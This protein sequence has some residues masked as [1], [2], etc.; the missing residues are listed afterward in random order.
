[1]QDTT[2][3]Q[4]QESATSGY[5]FQGWLVLWRDK[6]LSYVFLWTWQPSHQTSVEDYNSKEMAGNLE[7]HDV[8]KRSHVASISIVLWIESIFINLPEDRLE[9]LNSPLNNGTGTKHC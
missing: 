1:M 6:S 8:R 2:Q 5:I 7:I 4:K 9:G 3:P